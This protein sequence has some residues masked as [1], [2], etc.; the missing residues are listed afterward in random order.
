L[1][2]SCCNI[3]SSCTGTGCANECADPTTCT[4][5]GYTICN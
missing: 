3:S 4:G 5:D 2:L 1:G